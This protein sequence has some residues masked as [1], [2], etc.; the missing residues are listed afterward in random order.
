ML[1]VPGW[2][3]Y[4]ANEAFVNHAVRDVREMVRA[5]RNH[6]SVIL[7]ET[8]LNESYPPSWLNDAL[9]VC[10][11]SPAGAPGSIVLNVWKVE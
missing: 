4:S 2:Q 9:F 11:P 7:W 6:P 8:S 1:P 10:S 3:H 5:F